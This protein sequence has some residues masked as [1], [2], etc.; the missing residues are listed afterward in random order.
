MKIPKIR[1]LQLKKK[2]DGK[3]MQDLYIHNMVS[4]EHIILLREMNME[5]KKRKKKEKS[6]FNI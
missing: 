6:G 1:R 4:V 2:M 5:E 3:R